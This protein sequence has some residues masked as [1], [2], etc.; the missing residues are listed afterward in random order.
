MY[1][2]RAAVYLPIYLPIHIN[3][4]Y[5][6]YALAILGNINFTFTPSHGRSRET[7]RRDLCAEI[8]FTFKYTRIVRRTEVKTNFAHFK[9]YIYIGVGEHNILLSYERIVER[10]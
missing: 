2:P 8:F 6:I 4:I 5:Y 9:R 3:N 1:I 10:L 7:L